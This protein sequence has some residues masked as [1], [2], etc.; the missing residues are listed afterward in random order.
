MDSFVLDVVIEGVPS[1]ASAGEEAVW[2]EPIKKAWKPIEL[3]RAAGAEADSRRAWR[4]RDPES[5]LDFTVIWAPAPATQ[6]GEGGG[7]DEEELDSHAA[8]AAS[9]EEDVAED[10]DEEE[11]EEEESETDSDGVPR[12]GG[13]LLFGH[14]PR[15]GTRSQDLQRV[16]ELALRVAERLGLKL[17]DPVLGETFETE[18]WAYRLTEPFHVRGFVATHWVRGGDDRVSWV[19]THGMDR[20]GLPDVEAF[21]VPVEGGEDVVAFLHEAAI[22]WLREDPPAPSATPR[23]VDGVRV[24]V[25]DAKVARRR[26]KGYTDESWEDHDGSYVTIVPF[27]PWSTALVGWKPP[28]TPRSPS[29]IERLCA[30]TSEILPDV[31]HRFEEGGAS[32]KVKARFPVAPPRGEP[33]GFE[34]MWVQ[35]EEWKDDRI[36]GRLANDPEIR[37]DLDRGAAVTVAP[38]EVWDVFVV[39]DGQP[40]RGVSLRRWLRHLA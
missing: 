7:D 11:G 3:S 32:V 30:I 22:S 19:H 6:D 34:S 35:V 12:S 15:P 33:S 1:P 17:F 21:D 27:E 24:R 4:I 10:D 38:N 5:D 39:K 25:L 23:R 9:P 20:F 13:G 16:F 36:L 40:Y 8:Q 28:T 37:V 2:P 29:L 26:A 14:T 18:D 31:R